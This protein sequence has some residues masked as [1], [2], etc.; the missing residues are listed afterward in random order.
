M[1]LTNNAIQL[2][3]SK[4][5]AT[6]LQSDIPILVSHYLDARLKLDELISGRFCLSEINEAIEEVKTGSKIKNVIML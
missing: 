5:D 2:L 6:R 3:G 1:N 4:M